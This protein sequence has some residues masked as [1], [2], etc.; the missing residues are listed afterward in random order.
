MLRSAFLSGYQGMSKLLNLWLHFV[1]QGSISPSTGTCLDIQWLKFCTSKAESTSL[2]PG[3]GTKI[4]HAT[5]PKEKRKKKTQ[6]I[7]Y[8]HQE[9]AD[10]L[11]W[12]FPILLT[13]LNPRYMTYKNENNKA[14]ISLAVLWLRLCASN[15]G[16]A[17][18]IPEGWTDLTCYVV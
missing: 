2:I 18:L 14:R 12:W 3:R 17:D 13:F 16:G 7:L 10:I 1:S 4:P 8:K 15:A 5:W 11:L 6:V 9:D